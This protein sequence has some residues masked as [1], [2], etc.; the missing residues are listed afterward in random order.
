MIKL[1]GGVCFLQ[2]GKRRF[3]RRKAFLSWDWREMPGGS[4]HARLGVLASP[5]QAARE[6][7]WRTGFGRA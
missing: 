6:L 4:A 5:M 2:K 1:W 7:G 3:K